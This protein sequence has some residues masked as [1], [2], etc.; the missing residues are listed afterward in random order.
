L[1]Y[2]AQWPVGP[3]G[4]RNMAVRVSYTESAVQSIAKDN[5]RMTLDDVR[6][7]LEQG[8]VVQAGGFCWRLTDTADG[9]PCGP[10]AYTPPLE[11]TGDFKIE[12]FR[13]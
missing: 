9:D 8:R 12:T 13:R 4:D 5:G 6:G 11:H 2:L 10:G 3:A 7:C 1:T